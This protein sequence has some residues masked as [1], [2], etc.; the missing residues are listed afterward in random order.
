MPGEQ[1]LKAI[2]PN[3]QLR[4]VDP[5]RRPAGDVL[6]DGHQ[7]EPSHPRIVDGVHDNRATRP[8]DS[9]NLRNHT[10]QVG[11]VLQDLAGDHDVGRL[12]AQRQGMRVALNRHHSVPRRQQQ[13]GMNDVE[14]DVP[15][16]VHVR[17]E[18]P[19]TTAN[20]NQDRAGPIRRR[21]Q[22]SPRRR[23]PVERR[24]LPALLP[25]FLDEIVVLPRIVPRPSHRVIR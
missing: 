19:A 6:T 22:L 25:P 2:G 21:N 8:K 18:E 20:V 11:D 4:V 1:A 12:V 14:A 13:T 9:D 17:S 16:P 3:E 10:V 23:E 24:E 5:R 7:P 15:V